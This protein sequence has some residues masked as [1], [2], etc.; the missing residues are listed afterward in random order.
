MAPLSVMLLADPQDP[1][2]ALGR[3]LEQAGCTVDRRRRDQTL[4]SAVT[5]PAG[6]VLL[7]PLAPPIAGGLTWCRELRRA[8]PDCRLCVV[9][10]VASQQGSVAALE[11]GADAVLTPP[12][13]TS[14]LM[15]QL[16]ALARAWPGPRDR[17]TVG[18]LVIDPAV[19]RA[20]LSGRAVPL[21]DAE[22][23]LL[24]LLARHCGRVLDR[25]SISRELRGVPHDAR[26]RTID[27]RVARLRRKLGDDARRPCF[28]RSVRG[29]GYLF[30]APAR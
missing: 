8:R 30:S 19:R 12:V 18:P 23:D 2:P 20:T 24:L 10:P 15:A 5:V 11:M 3:D 29:E 13:A 25:E 26:D 17:V 14:H 6:A 9:L 16:R 21:T 22:F 1:A 27:L 28:I 7:L 4:P